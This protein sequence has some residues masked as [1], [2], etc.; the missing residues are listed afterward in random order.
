MHRGTGFAECSDEFEVPPLVRIGAAQAEFLL[1]LFE[2][3]CRVHVSD[4]DG[5]AANVGGFVGW[6]HVAL[7][8]LLGTVGGQGLSDESFLVGGAAPPGGEREGIPFARGCRLSGF[9]SSD[10]L[11]VLRRCS[12]AGF[13]RRGRPLDQGDGKA[14]TRT[15]REHRQDDQGEAGGEPGAAGTRG[16]WNLELV[17][18]VC[19]ESRFARR[20]PGEHRPVGSTT[21]TVSR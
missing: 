18:R 5:R 13:R 15:K 10:E 9:E 16:G 11:W 7:G 20:L 6:K 8:F 12:G 14:A 19:H 1:M 2:P 17:R 4:V 3:E 21:V